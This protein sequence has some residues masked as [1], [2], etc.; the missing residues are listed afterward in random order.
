M[1]NP[2]EFVSFVRTLGEDLE[3]MNEGLCQ[4]LDK[5]IEQL[6]LL[7]ELADA[8]NKIDG[9]V[10]EVHHEISNDDAEEIARTWRG[11]EF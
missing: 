8:H 9:G 11:G 1:P 3:E 6:D 10:I 7:I 5:I 2:F 4:R